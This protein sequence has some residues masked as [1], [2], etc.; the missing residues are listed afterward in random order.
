MARHDAAGTL[1]ADVTIRRDKCRSFG[2][3]GYVLA[4]F[5]KRFLNSLIFLQYILV[6][7]LL[8][9]AFENA[10]CFIETSSEMFDCWQLVGTVKNAE[11]HHVEMVRHQDEYRTAQ[12]VSKHGVR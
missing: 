6:P 8:Q 5:C 2:I 10:Q 1:V 9:F 4:D 11:P 12:T 3:S 7:L